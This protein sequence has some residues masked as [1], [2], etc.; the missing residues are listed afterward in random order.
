[1]VALRLTGLTNLLYEVASASINASSLWPVYSRGLPLEPTA[2]SVVHSYHLLSC[3]WIYYA[4]N[5]GE[6]R[7]VEYFKKAY[8]S[9]KHFLIRKRLFSRVLKMRGGAA[10][11][12]NARVS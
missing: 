11:A 8:K 4:L 5:R 6:R 12:I 3:V 2:G 7:S 1:M 10:G 9:Q